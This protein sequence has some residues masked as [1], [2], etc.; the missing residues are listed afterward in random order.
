MNPV[1]IVPC[2]GE[3]HRYNGT[4]KQF[5]LAPNGMPLPVFSASGLKKTG[6][7]IYTFIEEEYFKYY[8][9]KNDSFNGPICFLKNQTKSQVE[10]ISA[11]INDVGL[12][13]EAIY[14][15]DCDNYFEA[16]VGQNTITVK[17]TK[18]AAFK[19]Y[20][21]SYAATD[22]NGVVLRLAE[23]SAISNYINVG[24]YGFQSGSMFLNF[25]IGK[26]FIT[27]VITEAINNDVIFDVTYCDNYIDYGEGDDYHLFIKN[28]TQ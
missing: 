28:F 26:A 13:N 21:K 14:I 4:K 25:A 1:V 8:S 22:N 2:C 16:N 7:C 23:R 10:T 19:L 15:K 18:N 9:G 27:E 20:N 3:S 24:G 11:T 5:L 6:G 17:H 12:H